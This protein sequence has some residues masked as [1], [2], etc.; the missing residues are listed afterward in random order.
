MVF[1][2]Q[3]FEAFFVSLT[4]FCVM[5]RPTSLALAAICLVAPIAALAEGGS[6]AVAGMSAADARLACSIRAWAASMAGEDAGGAAA[7]AAGCTMGCLSSR[8]PGL[9]RMRG[10]GQKSRE[11]EGR[12]RRHKEQEA[13]GMGAGVHGEDGFDDIGGTL[14]EEEARAFA[15][16]KQQLDDLHRKAV[17]LMD[18][19]QSKKGGGGG[20]GGGGGQQ[21]EDIEE[22]F[23]EDER[24]SYQKQAELEMRRA[25]KAEAERQLMHEEYM[26]RKR[27]GEIVSS[28]EVM[29]LPQNCV[30]EETSSRQAVTKPPSPAFQVSPLLLLPARVF[31][32]PSSVHTSHL[33]SLPPPRQR[34]M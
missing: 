12:E 1:T 11:R 3:F 8:I 4:C 10:G 18:G 19:V 5:N 21:W 14:D 23:D 16:Q 7:A 28:E 20:G 17:S 25:E 6:R 9:L 2:P 32:T 29:A 33:V 15:D 26:E 24:F 30:L 27:R 13:A 34:T 22:E 31:S